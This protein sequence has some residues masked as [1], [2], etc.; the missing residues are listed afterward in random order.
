[1]ETPNSSAAHAAGSGASPVV[2]TWT[3]RSFV[4]N[5]DLAAAFTTLEFGRA[6]LRIDPAPAGTLTGLL[7]GP[8]WQL[9]LQGTITPGPPLAVRFQGTGVIN[10][11]EWIYDYLGYLVPAWPN[12][13]HQ[14]PAIVGSVIRTIPHPSGN[15]IAP[16]GVVA[17]WIGVKQPAAP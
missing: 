6:N 12:G 17:S 8:G 7:Y 2:G 15:G 16:A 10:G 9:T 3:Y 13:V 1:M 5:P 14:V 4:S 11:A